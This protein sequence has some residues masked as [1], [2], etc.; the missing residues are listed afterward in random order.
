[1]KALKSTSL[2]LLLSISLTA[3]GQTEK[4][5]SDRNYIEVVG[6]AEKRIVPDEIYISIIIRER[7]EGKEKLSVEQQEIKLKEA[8]SSIGVPLKNLSL[9]DVDA[10]YIRLKRTK[11][12]LSVTN[13]Y[14]L[15]IGDVPTV[16]KVFEILDE[17]RIVEAGISRVNHSQLTE[18]K[19]E[20]EIMAIKAAKEKASYILNAIG[21]NLGKPIY[22]SEQ[23]PSLP[24]GNH[25]FRGGRASNEVVFVDGV[26]VRGE[27]DGAIE[28]QKI[29]L[30]VSMYVKYEIL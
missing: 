15:K 18:F 6:T 7:E 17:M 24:S 27:V 11:K 13:E 25:Y 26:K 9:A 4:S 16:S 28:F 23:L 5:H 10:N 8:L 21:E 30:Q 2:Y 12:G 1:M 3:F 29:V 19:K 14:V 20:L 22:I